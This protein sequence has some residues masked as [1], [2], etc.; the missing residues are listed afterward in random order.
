MNLPPTAR[1]HACLCAALLLCLVCTTSGFSQAPDQSGQWSGRWQ[2]HWS[3][4]GGQIKLLQRGAVVTG[5]YPLYGMRLEATAEG[6]SLSGKWS[7]GDSPTDERGE[8]IVTL[9]K[10]GRMFS[11]RFGN[12]GWWTGE[13][14]VQTK[15]MAAISLRSPRDTV[16]G[17]LVACNRAQAGIKDAWGLAAEAVEFAT[18][19]EA[20]TSTTRLSRVASLFEIIDPATIHAWDIPDSVAADTYVMRLTFAG[21]DVVF[22]LTLHRDAQGDWR[23]V[24]PSETQ[25]VDALKAL[26]G[27]ANGKAPAADSYKQLQNPRAT[28]RAFLEGMTHWKEDNGALACSTMDLSVFPDVIRESN[29][30]MSAFYLRHALDNIGMIGLQSIPDDGANRSPYVHFVQGLGSIVIAPTGSA[31][32]APWQF[33][34]LTVKNAPMSF[35]ATASLPTP[36]FT[37]PGSFER[38]PYFTLRGLFV[39]YAPFLLVGVGQAEVWQL[40]LGLSGLA[41][42]IICARVIAALIVRWLSCLTGTDEGVTPQPRWFRLSITMLIVVSVMM[43]IPGILA[44]PANFRV[45]TIP[46]LGS[47]VC[48]A[49]VLVA[50]RLLTLISAFLSIRAART[51]KRTDDILLAFTIALLRLGVVAGGFL[52]IAKVLS[53]SA[54]NIIAGLGIG[55]LAFAFAS[56]ET[57]SNIFGAGILV[58]DRPF[59]RGDWIVTDGVEG[60]V[61]EVGIRSTRVRTFA[62][63]IIVVPNGKLADSTINN[64][65]T[66]RHRLLDLKL[67]VTEGGTPARLHSFIEAI[68]TRLEGDPSFVAKETKV[69]VVGLTA[70]AV[71]IQLT[72]YMDLPSDRA[73]SDT[74]HSLLTDL[75]DAAEA[76]GLTLSKAM[77]RSAK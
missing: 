56:R 68:R 27:R 4:G 9:S 20:L 49:A 48:I 15:E 37:P 65:G 55:G 41:L 3:D 60:S 40:I 75:M 53:F 76:S 71:E 8:F 33:T 24:E 14:I 57:L 43:Q 54:T 35:H 73:E 29:A 64:L 1:K 59:R 50:W 52:G 32:D 69:G 25:R 23:I 44:I 26:P 34:R 16:L 12:R 11:G 74:R 58:S 42:A 19:P 30:E 36:E 51:E 18:G 13:R 66:R 17:F 31:A 70:V 6:R 22:P 45:H 28:M 46:V 62:D 7:A 10:D 2:T 63:S 5:T 61:E 67:F 38:S 39:D 47:V 72:A 21:S 77:E